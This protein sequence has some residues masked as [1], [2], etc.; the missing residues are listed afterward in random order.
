M[1][2]IFG[3]YQ[4]NE[5]HDISSN[6]GI[7][8]DFFVQ[9]VR[10]DLCSGSS[11]KV[12]IDTWEPWFI[13]S[14][15]NDI[16]SAINDFDVI[17]TKHASLVSKYPD[18]CFFSPDFSVHCRTKLRG[19]DLGKKEFSVSFLT[20]RTM[21]G[22]SG[23]DQRRELW[24]RRFDIRCHCRFWSSNNSL[25]LADPRDQY[26]LPNDDRDVLYRSMFNICIENCQETNYFTE[27]I[28]DC[29]ATMTIPIY[30]GCPN[31][32]EYFNRDG[33]VM[34]NDWQQVID[35]CNSLSEMDYWKR[36]DASA[37]NMRR[38]VPDPWDSI[39]NHLRILIQKGFKK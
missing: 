35:V 3:P 37:D 36:M 32:V 28:K 18:K 6:L 16:E 39:E 13:T 7:D 5:L 23:Y 8:I 17:Y 33:I 34:A 27:K 10:R 11:L 1:S 30:I 9:F 22:S 15:A 29:F 19:Y 21:S 26:P 12:F 4:P 20:G 14:S 31:V 38:L 2:R 24:R 25:M